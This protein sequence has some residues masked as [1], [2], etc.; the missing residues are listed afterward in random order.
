MYCVNFL[1][2][3]R[4]MHFL[5]MIIL[6]VELKRFIIYVGNGQQYMRALQR[7]F[8]KLHSAYNLINSVDLFILNTTLR[9]T[10]FAIDNF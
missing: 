9:F 3:W 7:K 1:K 8:V 10:H 5:K 4:F 6:R 2:S